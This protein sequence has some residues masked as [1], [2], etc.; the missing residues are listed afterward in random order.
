MKKRFK[1]SKD[2]VKASVANALKRSNA[3]KKYWDDLIKEQK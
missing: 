3:K 2:I 1:K